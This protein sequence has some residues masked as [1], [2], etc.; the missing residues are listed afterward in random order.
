MYKTQQ[1]V[2]DYAKDGLRTL[3]LAQKTLDD[4][5][6]EEWNAKFQNALGEVKD[7]DAKVEALSSEIENGLFLL[8]STAIED[9]L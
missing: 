2:D 7:K 5:Y 8:G 9:Q 1:F 6:Y 4:E 3:L